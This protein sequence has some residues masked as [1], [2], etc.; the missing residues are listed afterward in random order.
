MPAPSLSANHLRNSWEISDRPLIDGPILVV[1]RLDSFTERLCAGLRD[2]GFQVI[3]APDGAR[4]LRAF[5][6]LH[7]AAVLTP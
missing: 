7:P 4:G 6:E 5:R 1:H 2:E 3:S